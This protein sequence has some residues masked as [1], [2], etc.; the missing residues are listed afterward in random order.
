MKRQSTGLNKNNQELLR[1]TEIKGTDANSYIWILKCRQCKYIY[2][3]DSTDHWE[4]KCPKCQNGRPRLEIPTEQDGKDWTR[5][6]HIIAFNLYNQIPFGT[7][8]MRN[9][10]VIE[11]AALLGRKVGSVS[12]KL[13]NLSRHDPALQARAD[14]G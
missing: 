8:H 10:R 2:G 6:E 12:N 1:K 13:G 9:P 11:L 5:E 3:C 7:M 4:R 14:M